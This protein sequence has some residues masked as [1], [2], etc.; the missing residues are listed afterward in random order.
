MRQA[1]R[2]IINQIMNICT[3]NTRTIND[4]NTGTIESL[5]NHGHRL[6]LSGNETSRSGFLV[7]NN[8]VPLIENYE[9]ISDRLAVLPLKT[10]FCNLVFLQCYLQTSNSLARIPSVSVYRHVG[11]LRIQ[12]RLRMTLKFHN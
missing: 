7:K 8:H 5:D 1:I 9:P 2:G 11:R 3:Y 6:F 12:G 4:L 10:K